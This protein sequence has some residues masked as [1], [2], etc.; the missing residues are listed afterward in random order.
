LRGLAAQLASINS[1]DF[2]LV[3]AASSSAN[4]SELPKSKQPTRS[5][6]A[7]DL[8]QLLIRLPQAY[9]APQTT[10]TPKSVF[11]TGATGFLGAFILRDLLD[12][13]QDVGHVTCLVRA[14]AEAE[15][16]ERLQDSSAGRGV[17]NQD[18]IDKK[19]LTVLVGDLDKEH[20]G[21]SHSTWQSLAEK[22]DTIV[23]N[24][25]LVSARYTKAYTVR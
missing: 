22:I 7:D 17:W 25:A 18:W 15:A 10:S 14:N 8:E 12:R 24:G 21:L 1:D 3:N 4:T 6:Y 13:T 20:F 9:S 2:G 5:I 11:L 23:H 19:R 16:L